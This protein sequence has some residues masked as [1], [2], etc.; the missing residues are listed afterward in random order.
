MVRIASSTF[1]GMFLRA[2]KVEGSVMGKLKEIGFDAARM[3]P[4]YT[5]EVWRK[6]LQVASREY[7]PALSPAAAEFELGSR[8]VNGYLET[9]VG[10]VIHAAMPF[11]SADTLCARLP[12][13]FTSGIVG[14]V[15]TPVVEK[16]GDK[17][18]Q[19]TLWGDGGVPWFTAGAVDA[20]LKLT[21]VKPSVKVWDVKP[22]SFT[23]D[24]TWTV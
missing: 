1:E 21:R 18:Y 8:M 15:K 16:L 20:T 5:V 19:V 7:Y 10:K 22:D 14:D 13:F 3:E 23:V 4:S 12:R 9:L 24:I 17:H 11:L 6:A 2:L